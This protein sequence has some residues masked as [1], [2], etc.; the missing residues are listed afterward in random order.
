MPTWTTGPPGG[1]SRWALT[2]RSAKVLPRWRATDQPS[3]GPGELVAAHGVG[4]VAR[5]REQAGV[6]AEAVA[7]GGHG[8]EQ[9]GGGDLG[10]RRHADLG[11]ETGLHPAGDGRLRDHEHAGPGVVPGRS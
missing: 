10:G 7:A 4:E 1:T 5:E 2:S 3:I 8:V 11:T 6:R 9:R